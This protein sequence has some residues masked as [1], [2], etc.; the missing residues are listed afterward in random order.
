MNLIIS[1]DCGHDPDDIFAILYLHS[2]GVNIR[3]ITIAEGAP[4]QIALVRFLCKEMGLDIPVGVANLNRTAPKDY[5]GEFEGRP[6]KEYVGFHYDLLRKYGYP[7]EAKGDDLGINV[8]A[9]TFKKYPDSDVFVIGPPKN[10]GAYIKTCNHEINNI[11]FQGGFIGYSEHN[12][13]CER[14]EKFE[15]KKTFKTFNLGGASKQTLDIIASPFVKN[16]RFVS[17][18][19]CHTI[20]YNKET[21]ALQ[22]LVDPKNRADE[23]FIDAMDLYLKKHNEKKFHDPCAAVCM[24]HPEI[25]SWVRGRLYYEKGEWGTIPDETSNSQII[26]DID[27][28]RF[29]QHIFDKD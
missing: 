26:A 27:R 20:L 29:W 16:L 25:A 2:T 4:H 6:I 18:N 14:L 28:D 19:V 12:Y 21:Q 17:K 3:A 9:E 5:N 22:K 11:T 23:I 10:L 7:V 8:M 13:P 15:G 1:S 24:L